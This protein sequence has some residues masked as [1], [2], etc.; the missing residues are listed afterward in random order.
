LGTSTKIADKT[1]D[2]VGGI[3]VNLELKLID[4]PDMDYLTTDK[5]EK[6]NPMPR[7]EICFR[8]PGVTPG[9]YKME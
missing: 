9:Y 1:L 4:I 5:D 8:G 6:G 7:G 3:G 2:H